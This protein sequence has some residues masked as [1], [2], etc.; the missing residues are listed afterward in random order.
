MKVYAHK[1]M[2]NNEKVC[3][4]P[5]RTTCT[6]PFGILDPQPKD[7]KDIH[8]IVVSRAC[9]M[10]DDKPKAELGSD[11][12]ESTVLK[13]NPVVEVFALEDVTK[14]V[15]LGEMAEAAERVSA[16]TD[17][18][19][20]VVPEPV[21]DVV[22]EPADF[23]DYSTSELMKLCDSLGIKARKNATRGALVEKLVA[24]AGTQRR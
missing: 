20:T 3:I 23:A 7:P 9:E 19:S 11:Y 22:E 6:A 14:D 18:V 10:V 1:W 21:S 16:E 17:E 12:V 2:K 5:F 4:G 15:D 13:Q 8:I 24:A